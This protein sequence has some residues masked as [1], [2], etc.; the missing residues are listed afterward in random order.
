MIWLLAL[1]FWQ[2]QGPVIGVCTSL[3]ND[4]LLAAN[5][6]LRL[7]E[8]VSNTFNPRNVSEEK[9]QQIL[10]KV[11]FSPVRTAALVIMLA[12]ECA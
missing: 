6:V 12:M 10:Q 9:F 3:S 8:S 2:Q 4:S 1:V 7:E 11:T 5:H